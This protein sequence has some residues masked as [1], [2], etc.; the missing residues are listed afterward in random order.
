M[1]FAKNPS[2]ILILGFSWA[3]QQHWF[4]EECPQGT[5]LGSSASLGL[6]PIP[7]MWLNILKAIIFLS[8]CSLK[9]IPSRTDECV[10][11]YTVVLFTHY[12]SLNTLTMQ[13]IEKIILSFQSNWT[14]K[15]RSS[16]T[17]PVVNY[18]CVYNVHIEWYAECFGWE[19]FFSCKTT[20]LPHSVVGFNERH[21]GQQND[22]RMQVC[23]ESCMQRARLCLCF[24]WLSKG[25]NLPLFGWINPTWILHT[26][27]VW[28]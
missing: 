26:R 25:L 16:L 5:G 21:R 3:A 28:S 19:M 15:V 8:I 11:N 1:C 20:S 22:S 23:K 9:T 27:L 4:G 6:C 17:G 13:G 24:P 2:T 12:W 18:H 14:R 7:E 10:I